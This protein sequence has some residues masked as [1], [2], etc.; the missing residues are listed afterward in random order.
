M[1]P[2][3]FDDSD[4]D[5]AEELRRR[6]EKWVVVEALLGD[7]IQ[8]ACNY[9]RTHNATPRFCDCNQGRLPCSCKP[10]AWKLSNG[11]LVLTEHEANAALVPGVTKHALFMRER[12]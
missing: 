12:L 11:L 8:K 10:D 3:K 6:G 2:R 9:R 7:G 4:L 5:K 1:M